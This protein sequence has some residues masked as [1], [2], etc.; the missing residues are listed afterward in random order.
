MLKLYID[1]RECPLECG[2][3]ISLGYDVASLA[4]AESGRQAVRVSLRV[5][6]TRET[7]L[8][9]GNGDDPLTAGR[10]N[11]RVHRAEV[12]ADGVPLF[13]GT[14]LLP[15]VVCR[16]SEARYEIEIKGDTALWARSAALRKIGAASVKFAGTLL[17]ADICKGWS[18][19]R[20]VK[21]FPVNRTDAGIHDSS[22]SLLPVD[23]VMSTDDYWPFISVEA[24]VRAIFEDA[25]YTVESRFM[26]GELFRSLYMSGG[27]KGSENAAAQ[28]ARM[29]FLAGRT[30]DVTA[31]ADRFGRVNMSASLH[32]NTVGNIVDTVQ[33]YATDESGNTVATGFFSAGNRFSVDEETGVA[34]FR[35]GSSVVV[36]FEYS[37]AYI[38]DHIITSRESLTGFDRLY[39]G[40]DTY[41]S[42]TLANNYDDQ[43]SKPQP[44]YGYKL[45]IFDYHKGCTYR[46]K[47][48]IDGEMVTVADTRERMTA[49]TMPRG[50]AVTYLSLLR[51]EKGSNI[52]NSQNDDWALY[53]GFVEER[54]RTE[55]EIRV[56]TPAET[57]SPSSPKY[58]DQLFI[59]GAREGMNF[60]LLRRTTVRPVFTASA[61]Y[62]SPLS[63]A[64]V[65]AVDIR[66]SD[67]LAALQHMF[68]LRFVTDEPAKKVFIE[69]SSE[70]FTG[71][72]VDWSDRIDLSQEI[73]LADP[74]C[75]LHEKMTFGY[76]GEDSAVTR[77]NNSAGTRLGRWTF[78]CTSQAALDGERTDLNPLFAPTVS[79]KENYF[80]ARSAY[81]MQVRDAED[82][83]DPV[84][85]TFSPR[86]VR[87]AGLRPLA[88][89]ERWMPPF[90]RGEYPLAAFH[91][92]GDSR[93]DGFTLCFEDRDKVQGLN[94]FHL[95]HL[96][97]ESLGTVLT[98]SLHL[99]PEEVAALRQ[100]RADAP[101][102]RSR[103]RLD[104]DGRTSGALYTLRSIDGYDPARAVARCSFTKIRE[105]KPTKQ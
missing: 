88:A 81:I 84:A 101:S 4:D 65:A 96:D 76:G 44:G 85:G 49:I 17:P 67:L 5:P 95:K 71:G 87:Y 53:Q 86:I 102:V 55:V 68:D 25:G 72:T 64:D 77:F 47:A 94:R 48:E 56:R 2:E 18:D 98:L 42:C 23:R 1:N 35:P 3:S 58:F 36:G 40:G 28:R 45:M 29:N 60:T 79:E 32:L 50:S 66:Q 103:F 8:I 30:T 51:A 16:G 99:H 7:A 91:F 63:F 80:E 90:D 52:F 27:Y 21:F 26:E 69:P 10:F 46:L 75:S 11:A 83:E 41:I 38:T 61:G 54:G 74:S 20:P 92:A 78:D 59:E 12:R 37:I 14:V 31:S 104:I 15:R 62:G 57:L 6:M 97:E 13:E 24:L 93:T 22:V 43:R 19:N 105:T 33:A 82:G 70:F 9:F 39:L 73:L 34:C 100:C 89:G